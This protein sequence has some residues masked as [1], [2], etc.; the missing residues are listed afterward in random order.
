M[1]AERNGIFMS[2]RTVTLK[3][4]PAKPAVTADYDE[5]NMKLGRPQ[6]PH[7]TIY[8]PQLTSMLSITHRMTGIAATTLKT[9][10]THQNFSR[11]GTRSLRDY[12]W[13]LCPGSTATSFSLCGNFRFAGYPVAVFVRCKIHSCFPTL[14]SHL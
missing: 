9:P 4:F 1:S 5:R 2:A 6:S 11:S 10:K 14:L 8:A 7:L 12:Y 13:R 3:P